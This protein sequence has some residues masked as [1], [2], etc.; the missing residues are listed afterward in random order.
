MA[1]HHDRPL[2]DCHSEPSPA[3][4]RGKRAKEVVAGMAV[5]NLLLSSLSWVI[6]TPAAHPSIVI[7]SEARNLLFLRFGLTCHPEP[8]CVLAC[9]KRAQTLSQMG[10]RDP[11]FLC[12]ALRCHLVYPERSR[13]ATRLSRAKPRGHFLAENTSSV[14][15]FPR[16]PLCDWCGIGNV[17]SVPEFTQRGVEIARLLFVVDKIPKH[18][19]ERVRRDLLD[20]CHRDALAMVRLVENLEGLARVA[21]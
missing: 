13:R 4:A 15:G 16:L 2:H 3:L 6:A 12:F 5:R 18:E 9:G 10:A 21:P 7:P 19:R 14:P 11:L 20:Y 17:P 1:A 8:S